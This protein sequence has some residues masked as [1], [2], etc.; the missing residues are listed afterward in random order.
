MTGGLINGGLEFI[1][2]ILQFSIF[3]NHL[4]FPDL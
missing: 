1:S 4:V 3:A 2:K